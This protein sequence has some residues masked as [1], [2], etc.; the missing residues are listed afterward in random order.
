MFFLHDELTWLKLQ[1]NK[2]Q[3]T[4]W[5]ALPSHAWMGSVDPRVVFQ[6][7]SSSPNCCL[8]TL[9]PAALGQ[10][11]PKNLGW[12]SLA[13]NPLYITRFILISS[14]CHHCP[15]HSCHICGPGD[16]IVTRPRTRSSGS[17]FGWGSSANVVLSSGHPQLSS[18]FFLKVGNWKNQG[19]VWA[20]C[21]Y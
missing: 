5:T 2:H 13:M 4:E 6:I 21:E 7:S 16:L 1:A 17:G 14:I 11:R 12:S 9:M 10:L 15:C 20:N 19:W 18:F 3:L 8:A